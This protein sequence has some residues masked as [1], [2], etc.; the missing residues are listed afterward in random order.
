M[1]RG[2]RAGCTRTGPSWLREAQRGVAGDGGSDTA[3]S[4]G[5][6]AML[7]A[8]RRLG[9]W[10]RRQSGTRGRLQRCSWRLGGVGC[11]SHEVS[12]SGGYACKVIQR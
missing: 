7:E 5:T 11:C 3:G 6:A 12:L 1:C 8:L 2:R 9:N 10:R 4:P